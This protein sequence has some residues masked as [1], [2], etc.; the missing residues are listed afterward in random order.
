M[1]WTPENNTAEGFNP[2]TLPATGLSPEVNSSNPDFLRAY[3]TNILYIKKGEVGNITGTEG[4]VDI[5]SDASGLGYPGYTVLT[6]TQAGGDEG[7]VLGDTE[8]GQYVEVISVGSEIS[9]YN[10]VWK[11]LAIQPS[12]SLIIDAPYIAPEVPAL[13]FSEGPYYIGHSKYDFTDEE[14][15]II[16]ESWSGTTR[17]FSSP[18]VWNKEYRVIFRKENA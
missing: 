7:R 6:D 13:T 17:G 15:S 14:V 12:Y 9:M 10:G 18:D 11:V 16:P 4:A 1:A 8:V 2:E 5:F 3:N